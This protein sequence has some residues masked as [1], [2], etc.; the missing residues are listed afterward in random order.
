MKN[1]HLIEQQPLL[2]EIYKNRALTQRH[3][4]ESQTTK[5]AILNALRSQVGPSTFSMQFN[6]VSFGPQLNLTS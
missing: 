3:T 1:W 5:K 2:S 4:R 6:W